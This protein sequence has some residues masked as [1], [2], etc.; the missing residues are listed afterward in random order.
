[1]FT[2]C[3]FWWMWLWKPH[4]QT[5][6]PLS[7]VSGFRSPRRK[8]EKAS[9]G[10]CCYSKKP[11]TFTRRK[12]QSLP[13]E[14]LSQ[15]EF[16]PSPARPPT[17]CSTSDVCCKRVFAPAK[18]ATYHKE[19]RGTNIKYL[20]PSSWGVVTFGPHISLCFWS[21][22][23]LGALKSGIVGEYPPFLEEFLFLKWFKPNMGWHLR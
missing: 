14:L 1:M 9:L 13:S 7:W 11:S 2:D 5:E 3:R 10:C 6:E 21:S 4:T 22:R 15:Q 16:P 18:L 20:P 19:K 17:L 12:S 8:E 23:G